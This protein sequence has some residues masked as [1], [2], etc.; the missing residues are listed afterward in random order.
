MLSDQDKA[1]LHGLGSHTS[2]D[3]WFSSLLY[4]EA[5]LDHAN[6]VYFDGRHLLLCAYPVGGEAI[7]ERAALAR[8]TRDWVRSTDAEVVVLCAPRCPDLRLLAGEGLERFHTWPADKRGQELIARCPSPDSGTDRRRRRAMKAPF[9]FRAT[10]GGQ[11]DVDKL[12]AIERF[13]RVTGATPYVAALTAAWMAILFDP[14]VHFLEAWRDDKSLAAFIALHQPFARG[15]VALAMTRELDAPGVTDFLYAHMIEYG[16]GIGLD[17]IN[18]GSSATQGQHAF[19]QKWAAP[20]EWPAFALTEWRRPA[21]M[22]RRHVLWGPRNLQR[23]S[24]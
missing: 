1:R 21:L 10:R 15:G 4:G 14:R 22:R 6:T 11:L 17:W 3:H 24:S 13:Q 18:L 16:S 2:H 19:K 7:Q 20:S 23:S 9:T 8:W 5:T 12:R